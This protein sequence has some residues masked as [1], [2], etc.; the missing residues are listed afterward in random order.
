MTLCGLNKELKISF[1]AYLLGALPPNEMAA[2]EKHLSTECGACL[3]E[4]KELQEVLASLACST[5]LATPSDQVR[6]KLMARA[7]SEIRPQKPLK[8]V[9]MPKRAWYKTPLNLLGKVAAALIVLVVLAETVLLVHINK[10]ARLTKELAQVQEQK[11][12]VLQ[13]ELSQKQKDISNIESSIKTSRKMVALD[14]KLISNAS[15]KAFWDT[16]Q[17]DWRFYISD[18]PNAPKGRVYQLWFITDKQELIS[19]GTFQTNEKGFMELR[20]ATPRNCKNIFEVA[21]SLEPEGGSQT[22]TGAI[23]LSGPII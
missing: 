22:P 16:D 5:P 11:I 2:I 15:G 18:L 4:I 10:K 9:P 7:Q 21:I 8:L 6:Q 12:Q 19:G 20:L 1:D 13:T 3:Q 17:N 23:Y 14:S